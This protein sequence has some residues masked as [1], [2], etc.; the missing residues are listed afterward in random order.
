MKYTEIEQAADYI[1]NAIRITP[2]IAV[3]L[4]SGLGGFA[5]SIE[6]QTVIEYS[7]IPNFP[8]SSAKG[9]DGKIVFGKLKGK[10]ILAFSG[11]V[12]YYEGYSMDKVAFPSAVAKLL[13]CEKMII[14]NAAGGINEEYAPGELMLIKDHIKL[15][16][17]NPLRG[18][19]HKQLG[20]AFCDMSSAYN[21]TLREIAKDAAY[22]L[23]LTLH[24]GIY[25]YMSGP[26]YETPAEVRMLRLLGA[27]AV[28][29]STVPEV[30]MAI[31]CGMD[32]LGVSYITNMASGI[33]GVKL[34]HD[35]V[36]EAGK[37]INSD[38]SA[39]ITNIIDRI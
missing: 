10:Y 3:I 7:E 2:K 37:Y 27:D 4:G 31:S 8:V 14:T 15:C 9:H 23:G 28:G 22:G 36:L 20:T 25:A 39:L 11:R 5:D 6:E 33:S 16:A 35:E 13:G 18:N 30:I 1:R 19:I 26:C 34:S 32:V 29:M 24:E 38:F 21:K 12:H 17:E